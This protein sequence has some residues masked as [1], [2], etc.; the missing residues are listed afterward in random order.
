MDPLIRVHG[1]QD[2][3]WL[4]SVSNRPFLEPRAETHVY[5]LGRRKGRGKPLPSSPPETLKGDIS[6][7]RNVGRSLSFS[8]N[9]LGGV[10]IGAK[11]QMTR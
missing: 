4:A 6:R 10:A 8:M 9:A 11:H 5:E 1:W 3:R 7:P 2:F